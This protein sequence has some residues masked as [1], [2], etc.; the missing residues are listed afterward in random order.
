[1]IKRLLV[2]ACVF[3]M[4]LGMTLPAYAQEP[5]SWVQ[6][7]LNA[8]SN[9]LGYEVTISQM[10]SWTWE[11]MVFDDNT[12]GCD[13]GFRAAGNTGFIVKLRLNGTEYDYRVSNDGS[14]VYQCWASADNTGANAV[15]PPAA[16]PNVPGGYQPDAQTYQAGTVIC[17]GALPSYLSVGTPAMSIASVSLNIR[18]QPGA[19]TADSVRG[20]LLPGGIVSIIGGPYCVSNMTWWN[21][22]HE[23]NNGQVVTGWVAEG[24]NV[25]YWL[26]P[27]GGALAV[28]PGDPIAPG[29]NNGQIAPIMMPD[30][31]TRPAIDPTNA[32]RLQVVAQ[33]PLTANLAVL[34]S[35]PSADAFVVTSPANLPMLYANSN[36]QA[37]GLTLGHAGQ[38]VR[39]L[40][41]VTNLNQT[42]YVAATLE[43]NPANSAQTLLYVWEVGDVYTAPYVAEWFGVPLPFD[44]NDVAL[45][46]S[47]RWVVVTSGTMLVVDPNSPNGVWVWETVTGTQTIAF[48]LPS[49]GSGIAFSPDERYMAVTSPAAETYVFDTSTWGIVATLPGSP[50]L[51]GSDSVTFSP[52]GRWLAIGEQSSAVQIYDTATWSV[53]RTVTAPYDGAAAYVDFTSDSTVLAV[54]VVHMSM[55]HPTNRMSTITLWDINTGLA[56]ASLMDFDDT[57]LALGFRSEG[58]QLVAIGT[59]SWSA[60]AVE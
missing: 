4:L 15:S 16:V 14:I 10:S 34:M 19:A 31:A 9:D 5:P 3:V 8:L 50:A 57:L 1:M 11:Q 12:L 27:Y 29:G 32:P 41:L 24:D 35:E 23:P 37:L 28:S 46:S 52:D 26:Q 22:S 7:A 54:G 42:S 51:N 43:N 40:D 49:A 13:R 56:V 60:W 21:V 30:L 36:R 25:D 39:T 45:S 55:Q 47:G 17:A 59:Q 48:Q 38:Y 33:S 53:F 6:L 20:L 58:R 18:D 2:V 44:A